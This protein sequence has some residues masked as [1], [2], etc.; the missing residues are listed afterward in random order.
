MS[1]AE[2]AETVPGDAGE[3]SGTGV[4]EAGDLAA[5]DSLHQTGS[6]FIVPAT[7]GSMFRRPGWQLDGD[8]KPRASRITGTSVIENAIGPANPRAVTA[9]QAGSD[10]LDSTRSIDGSGEFSNTWMAES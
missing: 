5:S 8:V 1:L 3:A 6:M 10:Q 7:A 4:A 9:A 2:L